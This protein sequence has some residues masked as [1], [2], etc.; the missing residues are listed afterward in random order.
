MSNPFRAVSTIL[1]V[2]AMSVA[3]GCAG[4]GA[5]NNCND[6]I[7]NDGDGLID[8]DDPGCELNGN[9]E[10]PD[11]D[12]PECSDRVD[13][14]GDGQTDFP[15]DQ[16]CD[17]PE[18]N[19][20]HS[21]PVPQCKDGIDNDGDGLI[22]FPT[23]PGC[24]VSLENDESDDCPSGANCPKCSNGVDDDDDGI[25]DYPDD[26]GCDRA[27][28]D[29]EFN[30]DPSI[31]GANV[32]L[33]PL[34]ADGIATGN[35][36]A[37]G[38]NDLIS[39]VCGG[40]GEEIVYTVNLT[41]PTTL[42]V[43]TDF[44]ETTVDTVL[45]VRSEC[46]QQ[47]TEVGCND[48]SVGTASTMQVDVPAGVYYIV[49]DAHDS[50]TGGDFRLEV[51]QYLPEKAE[52]DPANSL[53]A[54]GLICRKLL[55]TSTTE[56]CEKPE[57]SDLEDNDSDGLTDYPDEPGC[58]DADD[59]DETDTC[60]GAGCPA[61]ANGVDDDI[62]GLTDFS[63]GDPGCLS[64]SDDN[65]LDECIP[66]V[67]VN[68]L[69]PG[70]VT[71][72]TSGSGN[73]VGSCDSFSN[74]GEDVY[75]Y[76]LDRDLVSLSFTTEGSTLDTVTHVRFGVC[77]SAAAEIACA[78]PFPGTGEVVTLNTP[79]QGTYFVF[80]DGDFST[81]SYMLDVRGI[82]GAGNACD[83]ADTN[84][85]CLAGYACDGT[86][87]TCVLS[88]C[89][90]TINND[91]D[92]FTDWPLDPGCSSISDNDETDDCPSGMNCPACGNEIDD[93]MDGFI[94][95]LD[96][97]CAFAGDDDEEDCQGETEAVDLITAAATSSTNVAATNDFQPTCTTS[98]GVDRV[99]ILQVPFAL[100]SLS[101][102]TEGSS[103]D[104]VLYMTES[105]CSGPEIACDDDG[106]VAAGASAFT[107]NTVAAANYMIYVDGYSGGTGT[108]ALNVAGTIAAGGAC[109]VA[110]P[111]FTCPAAHFCDDSG[112]SAVCN[113]A[114][115]ADGMDND[116]D[117]LT[118]LFDPGCENPED[119]TEDPDPSPLPECADGIDNDNDG[120]IDYVNGDV[121]CS[122]AFDDDETNCMDSD[123]ILEITTTPT[124]GDTTGLTD[125]FLPSC[126]GN[127]TAPD[128]VYELNIPGALT[129]LN[130]NTNNTAHD[131]VLM[132]K[133]STCTTADFAC[134][135]DGGTP[136]LQSSIT[137][138]TVAA[139]KYYI[140]VD[141][142]TT[143][144]GPF[145]LNISGV[146][147]AGEACDSAQIAAGIFSCAAGTT[148]MDPGTGFVCQ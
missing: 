90:D 114:A 140:I 83:P 13:N 16:G 1:L 126:Q 71:G 24:F 113:P 49:V 75:S 103:F 39:S 54:P 56:T 58:T 33:L 122:Q 63:G 141:G 14:D 147:T 52:C 143:N 18:D 57:C 29:D 85:V 96:I 65:E 99:F 132:L 89:N 95:M 115:C 68:P 11:P 139:G 120:V 37:G 46:R 101:V 134:D 92:G 129:S 10:A 4:S 8:S 66:G 53:C 80:V 73:F 124:N 121:G 98:V 78:D 146:I 82:I 127:S 34:P 48:D 123:P 133:Q 74:L 91:G 64:A 45:Y 22:D 102:D 20:E 32:D 119:S 84:F 38:S 105:T 116:M 72:T 59:N 28:D 67:T 79:T 61:C 131:T 97:G 69:T 44:P 142:Y 111:W 15:D 118:D 137:L 12:F 106:G 130:I 42:F 31:C 43:T 104:T 9:V 23:D 117:G 36:A 2:S 94:D 125:D 112:A 17:T 27:S 41:V 144:S 145:I 55:P 86:S 5:D 81:G 26:P 136:G 51:S 109:D 7:D 76:V 60:P 148:C 100:D 62:D 110:K 138:P 19:K 47:P 35:L 87:N 25:T 40:G 108:I 88:Q 70:G 135:D 77:D 3:L 128:A 21:D 107:V 6:G 50:G 30:A 93:D